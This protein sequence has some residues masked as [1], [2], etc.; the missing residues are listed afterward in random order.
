MDGGVYYFV[1][2]I[3]PFTIDHRSLSRPFLLLLNRDTSSVWAL[4]MLCCCYAAV[5]GGEGGGDATIFVTP[6]WAL[7]RVTPYLSGTWT[8]NSSVGAAQHNLMV[9]HIV[10]KPIRVHRK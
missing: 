4:I 8:C 7:G 10:Q 3:S 9:V 2:C 5:G 6:D 1:A